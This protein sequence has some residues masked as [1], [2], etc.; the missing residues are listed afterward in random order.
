MADTARTLDVFAQ[1]SSGWTI[2]GLASYLSRAGLATV[3]LL[4]IVTV[5]ADEIDDP[6][7]WTL[8]AFSA[9]ARVALFT[10]A[11]GRIH[12]VRSGESPGRH[13]WVVKSI[14]SG[15][16][17]LRSGF[18]SGMSRIPGVLL[19]EGD[20]IPDPRSLRQE[21]Q[22]R[23]KVVGATLGSDIDEIGEGASEADK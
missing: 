17:E 15:F 1:G 20:R 6:D 19:R 14:G 18:D 4:G 21:T 22:I 11:Q 8:S 12:K 13:D 2:S 5:Q 10:D 23:Y 9:E 3:F 16:I 7:V